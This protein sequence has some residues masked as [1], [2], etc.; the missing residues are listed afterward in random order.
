VI[1][2][3]AA[4]LIVI[5][6]VYAA[7]CVAQFAGHPTSFIRKPAV[8]PSRRQLRDGALFGLVIAAVVVLGGVTLLRGPLFSGHV[9]LG[10]WLACTACFV[11]GALVLRR[12]RHRGGGTRPVDL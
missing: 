11:V 6:V 7:L 8:E 9:G 1:A 5:G 10:V 12:R 3:A 4:A 2:I